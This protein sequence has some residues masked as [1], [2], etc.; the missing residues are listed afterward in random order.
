VKKLLQAVEEVAAQ[1]LRAIVRMLLLII[2]FQVPQGAMFFRLALSHQAC[3][4]LEGFCFD[5]Y[6][7]S[8]LY[9]KFQMW[10]SL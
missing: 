6:N 4:L 1:A 5:R 7:F 8:V 3:C 9:N 10:R 2:K